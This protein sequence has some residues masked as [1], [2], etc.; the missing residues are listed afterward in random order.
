M[1][2]QLPTVADP[3]SRFSPAQVELIKHTV[4]R[5]ASDVELEL[6]LYQCN[7]TGLDPFARQIYSIERRELRDGRWVNSRAVQLSIDGLRLIAE[8]S[9][10]YAGQSGPFWCGPDGQW[11]DVWLS[12]DP[13][14]AAKIGVLRKDFQEPCWGVARF[15]AYAA[16]KDGRPVAMWAKMADVM[17]AKCAEALALRKAFPQELSGLYTT[18]EMDQATPPPPQVLPRGVPKHSVRDRTEVMWDEEGERAPNLADIDHEENARRSEEYG[19]MQGERLTKAL[20]HSLPPVKQAAIRCGDPIFWKYIEETCNIVIGGSD[21]AATWIRAMC[22][23]NSRSEFD[24]NKVAAG[25]WS[26]IDAKFIAWKMMNP[27]APASSTTPQSAEAVGDRKAGEQSPE[28]AVPQ[29]TTQP[30]TPSD[31]PAGEPS[32]PPAGLSEPPRRP[33]PPNR[34]APTES[35]RIANLDKKLA[36]AAE[37]GMNNLEVMWFQLDSKDR[38]TLKVA[39]DRWHKPRAAEVDSVK[40]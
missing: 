26:N 28:T 17:I 24:T 10:K 23:I 18:E 12:S 3:P 7:R 8:R 37:L 21:A 29:V 6:F 32:V 25:H 4:C 9:N 13:P 34:F 35:E 2:T 30:P 33:A 14:T 11:T 40:S 19:E 15:D 27:P 31:V 20:W 16:K 22:G 38:K 36:K 5:G 1:N 39:L